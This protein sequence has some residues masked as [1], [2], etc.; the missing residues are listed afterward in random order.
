[1]QNGA[2]YLPRSWVLLP[3]LA[4]A[5]SG[6]QGWCWEGAAG[7][8]QSPRQPQPLLTPLAALVLVCRDPEPLLRDRTF[9]LQ[10]DVVSGSPGDFTGGS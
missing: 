4:G 1:M 9:L 6:R 3:G 5:G 10:L 8:G 7:W 2:I